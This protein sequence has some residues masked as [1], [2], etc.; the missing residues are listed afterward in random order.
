[1]IEL[2]GPQP[3]RQRTGVLFVVVLVG[4]IV[5]ISVQVQSHTGV[6]VLEAAAFGVF[7]R[8]QLALAGVVD[9]GRN[10]W[11]N[12]IGLRG[13]RAENE[14][15][16]RQLADMEVRLQ[17]QRALA[18]RSEQLQQLLD[19]QQSAALPTVA[20][21]VIAGNP[22]PGILSV[23]VNRGSADGVNTDMA[24]ISPKGIVGR[25]VGRPT[26][27]ASRVQLLIDPAAAA[28]ALIERSRAGGM[29]AGVDEDPPLHLQLVSNLADV[30]VG[31][32]VVA[33]GADGVYPRG[34]AIGKVEKS[35]RGHGLYRAITVRPAVDFSSIEEVL[36]V[37]VPA[38]PA[39]PPPEPAAVPAER[40]K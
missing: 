40:T 29:V 9:V 21:E 2:Q 23:T 28:A 19:L 38:R 15:L 22:N 4:H 36:I 6:P 33:S 5:L 31:D 26:A 14:S 11:G 16:K 18:A 13:A 3:L 37:L 34:F 1:V 30:I 8:V 39:G 35:E 20:A 7:S 27:H 12:Y 10:G 24:V 32:T 25:V 17:E